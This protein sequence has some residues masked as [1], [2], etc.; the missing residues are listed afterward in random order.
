MREKFRYIVFISKS[1]P[2]DK[3]DFYKIIVSTLVE[4]F[5]LRSLAFSRLTL[6]DY[7]P[8]RGGVIKVRR[9]A[10]HIART[11]LA[12]YKNNKTPIRV[13]KI[14]GTLRKAKSILRSYPCDENA[15]NKGDK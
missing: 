6:V 13:I 5:G 10:I 15:K 2:E 12:F 14:A 8:G 11:A 4:L 1:L 9:E 7:I 3:D